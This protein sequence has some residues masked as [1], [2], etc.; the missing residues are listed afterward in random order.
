MHYLIP[1]RELSLRALVVCFLKQRVSDRS[2]YGNNEAT[3]LFQAYIGIANRLV[4]PLYNFISH[5]S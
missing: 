2:E 1:F 3:S 4:K 5:K